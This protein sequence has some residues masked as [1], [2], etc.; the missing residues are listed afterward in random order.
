[1]TAPAVRLISVAVIDAALVLAGLARAEG[2]ARRPTPDAGSGRPQS[3]TIGVLSFW[4]PSAGG[5]ADPSLINMAGTV[6]AGGFRHAA[7]RR[8]SC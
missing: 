5:V 1:M 3:S 2:S 6:C 4:L 8:H 7:D